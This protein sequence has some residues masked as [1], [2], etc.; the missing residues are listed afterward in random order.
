M[1]TNTDVPR[2]PFAFSEAV[3]L[4]GEG[5]LLRTRR[6]RMLAVVL[7]MLMVLAFVL[8]IY[9]PPLLWSRNLDLSINAHTGLPDG[10]Y[11]LEPSTSM[12]EGDACWFR[13]TVRGMPDYGEVTVAGR[14]A[15]Q[16]AG[17]ADYVGRVLISVEGG[18]AAITPRGGG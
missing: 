17:E 9:G 5:A 14:G 1:A 12:H 8:A 7:L 13:G 16:C 6:R 10:S 2:A 4:V 15:P 3:P 11:V 18:T